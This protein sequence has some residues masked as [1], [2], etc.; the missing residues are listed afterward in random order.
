MI[1][2]CLK[3]LS[4]FYYN[5]YL[6]GRYFLSNNSLQKVQIQNWP[7][8]NNTL[9]LIFHFNDWIVIEMCVDVYSQVKHTHLYL[10]LLHLRTTLSFSIFF[11][12]D[13]ICNILLLWFLFFLM[14]R[15]QIFVEAL[16]YS[17]NMVKTEV[18][19]QGSKSIY[20]YCFWYYKHPLD[21]KET[22]LFLTCFIS[23]SQSITQS[24]KKKKTKE[25]AER[26]MLGSLD[27]KICFLH[28]RA[29]C[30]CG[31]LICE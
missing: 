21:N 2:D 13:K 4:F 30:F 17:Y 12:I 18:E 15:C 25:R 16:Y 20:T 19:R 26:Q 11:F 5:K 31:C 6:L 28:K 23:P 14:L 24:K 3:F 29:I 7:C 8:K 10:W 27:K 1:N 22:R 9:S